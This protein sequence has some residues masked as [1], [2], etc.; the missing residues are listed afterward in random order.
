MQVGN[1][2]DGAPDFFH[3]N[4]TIKHITM[5]EL[6]IPNLTFEYIYAQGRAAELDE[7][8]IK[9]IATSVWTILSH[10]ANITVHQQQLAYLSELGARA[11]SLHHV[12]VDAMQQLVSAYSSNMYMYI[13]LAL[14]VLDIDVNNGLCAGLISVFVVACK[15]IVTLYLLPHITAGLTFVLEPVVAN[16]LQ[17]LSAYV[18]EIG[19]MSASVSAFLVKVADKVAAQG[20]SVEDIPSGAHI[21]VG[22]AGE[23]SVNRIFHKFGIRLRCILRTKYKIENCR[24]AA[25]AKGPSHEDMFGEEFAPNAFDPPS[26]RPASTKW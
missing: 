2:F 26:R 8:D 24:C 16:L 15:A 14:A 1:W 7:D 5:H 22:V 9:A 6:S 4:Y 17:L 18:P 11:Q 23:F 25:P 3:F 10:P 12:P 13:T 19:E 21:G 20:G